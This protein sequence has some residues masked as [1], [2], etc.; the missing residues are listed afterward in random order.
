VKRGGEEN[1]T[2]LAG[3]GMSLNKRGGEERKLQ[4]QWRDLVRNTG[5]VGGRGWGGRRGGGFQNELG[6]RRKD[7]ASGE[8][9]RTKRVCDSQE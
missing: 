7:E 6:S 2:H 9:I 1:V 3:F 5:L 4:E 8:G